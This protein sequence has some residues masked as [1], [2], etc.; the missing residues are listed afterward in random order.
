[1]IPHRNNSGNEMDDEYKNK[2]K[3]IAQEALK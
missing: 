1:M 2:N 3:D